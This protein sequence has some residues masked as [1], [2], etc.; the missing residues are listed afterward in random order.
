MRLLHT[1]DDETTARRFGDYLLSIGIASHAEPARD[2]G[3]QLWIEHDDHLD[4]ARVELSL[5][6]VRPDDAKFEAGNIAA[7]IRK[8]SQIAEAK[9]RKNYVDVRT[10]VIYRARRATPVMLILLAMCVVST[11]ATR[12][13]QFDAAMTN[14]LMFFGIDQRT[15][16]AEMTSVWGFGTARIVSGQVWRLLTPIFLHGSPMHLIFNMTMLYWI[17]GMLEGRK[18]SWWLLGFVVLSGVVSNVAQA[19]WMMAFGQVPAFLGFSGVGYAMFGFAWIRGKVRPHEQIGVD[20]YT[21]SAMLT[22]FVICLLGIMP[23][24]NAAH[25]AGLLIGALLGGLPKLLG[26]TR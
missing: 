1:F 21:T 15:T 13:G 8:Q 22:W 7:T 9:R 11:F 5:F 4:R 14:H 3:Q 18:G 20:S 24:A 12:F 16:D 26:R 10:K 23:I 17:G 19:T 2:G 6:E 25:T